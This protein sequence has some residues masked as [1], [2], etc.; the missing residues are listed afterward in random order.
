MKLE[1]R[2]VHGYGGAVAA[3][4]V[5]AI[6]TEG[7]YC[8]DIELRNQC[9]KL[10]S[11]KMPSLSCPP[12][13]TPLDLKRLQGNTTEELFYASF[14]ITGIVDKLLG[15]DLVQKPTPT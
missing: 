11:T 7:E 1:G 8:K 3:S 5:G 12:T 6:S 14:H 2:I 9:Q 13:G 4:A 10:L 15:L